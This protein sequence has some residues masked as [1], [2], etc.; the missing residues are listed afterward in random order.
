MVDTLASDL[1]AVVERAGVELRDVGD[2]AAALKP[3]P[4]VWSSKEIVGHLIDSASNN[5]HRFVRAQEGGPLVF[6]GYEQNGWVRIQGYQSQPWPEL[7]DLWVLYNRHLA[8]VIRRTPA[9]ALG[10]LC[11]VG[12]T[13]GVAL[14]VVLVD[15]VA[16]VKHHLREISRR[17]RV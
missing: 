11:Q 9:H 10:I 4:E 13:N 5:H 7:V 14:A 2:E 12:D 8:H 3:G 17:H 15:Y 16:H 6:P 1:I